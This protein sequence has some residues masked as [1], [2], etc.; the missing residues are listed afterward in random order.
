M[1]NWF[2][3]VFRVTYGRASPRI[4]TDADLSHTFKETFSRP[5]LLFALKARRS[6]D[7]GSVSVT[8]VSDP[9]G[10]WRSSACWWRYLSSPGKTCQSRRRQMSATAARVHTPPAH[11]NVASDALITNTRNRL[12]EL[13]KSLLPAED[14]QEQGTC[15]ANTQPVTNLLN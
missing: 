2:K 15:C 4:T 11:Q 8:N 14:E 12:S 3:R 9:R 5:T 6:N 13:G 7:T 10:G 1:R